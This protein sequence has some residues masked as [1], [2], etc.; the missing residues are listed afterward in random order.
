VGLPNPGAS[1][2]N[3]LLT[4]T[5]PKTPAA[6]GTMIPIKAEERLGR[7]RF[8]EE[9]ALSECAVEIEGQDPP[10]SSRRRSSQDPFAVTRSLPSARSRPRPVGAR[11]PQPGERDP[12]A[13]GSRLS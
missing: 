1:F 12:T 9:V 5:L 13:R 8:L 3:G 11:P 4:V 10:A 6:K 7:C 2:K